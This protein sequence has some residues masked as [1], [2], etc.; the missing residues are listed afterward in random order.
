[1][2][3]KQLLGRGID[4][5]KSNVNV[6]TTQFRDVFAPAPETCLV[7]PGR[8]VVG[9]ANP[10]LPRLLI[11]SEKESCS[12]DPDSHLYLKGSPVT[13]LSPLLFLHS[14][15]SSSPV[16]AQLPRPSAL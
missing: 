8:A 3:D 9:C 11:P 15:C 1:M 12:P 4:E 2:N 14:S 13:P 7:T 6:K 5:T 10:V 16:V